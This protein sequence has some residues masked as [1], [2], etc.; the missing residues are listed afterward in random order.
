MEPILSSSLS[1]GW[2]TVRQIASSAA[3]A[4][5]YVRI[6]LAAGVFM[7]AAPLLV[8]IYESWRKKQITN[9]Y[10]QSFSNTLNPITLYLLGVQE[11]RSSQW[12]SSLEM[13]APLEFR[14]M[15]L[16][17]MSQYQLNLLGSRANVV[18][19]LDPPDLYHL[20]QNIPTPKKAWVASLTSNQLLTLL[21][22]KS[23]IPDAEFGTFD[24]GR[25]EP[26]K[27]WKIPIEKL[28]PYQLDALVGRPEIIR[29]L[30]P[31]Q[32]Q[33]LY[34]K[35]TKKKEFVSS[36][37]G[38]NLVALLNLA[39]FA[40]DADFGTFDLGA[41]A[42]SEASGISF[43]RLSQSQLDALVLRTDVVSA[44]STTAL[45]HLYRAIHRNK[46]F[47]A[48]LPTRQLRN[49]LN[50]ENFQLGEESTAAFESA[51]D[52]RT[53]L[54]LGPSK[55]RTMPP[56]GACNIKL[57]KLT[58][59]QLKILMSRPEA[60][61]QFNPDQLL[62]LYQ[63][64]IMKHEEF[65]AS[66][67]VQQLLGLLTHRSFQPR[68]GFYDIVAQRRD[69][70]HALNSAQI[71]YLFQQ[72]S[73]ESDFVRRLMSSQLVDLLNEPSFNL[74]KIFE[75]FDMTL[76]QQ[77]A[78]VD[79]FGKFC[80]V[81]SMH[82]CFLLDECNKQSRIHRFMPLSCFVQELQKC[83]SKTKD[84]IATIPTDQ[85]KFFLSNL[86]LN[87]FTLL[88]FSG[89]QLSSINFKKVPFTLIE[90]QDLGDVHNITLGEAS[91]QKW[92]DT[93]CRLFA[94]GLLGGF[95]G[96]STR[97]IK[98]PE[99]ITQLQQL[100]AQ[101]VAF[102]DR[103]TTGMRNK[104][105]VFSTLFSAQLSDKNYSDYKRKFDEPDTGTG[106]SSK[107]SVK[108]ACQILGLED[109]ATWDEIKAKYRKMALD[110]HP[111]R[112]EDKANAD[113]QKVSEA[114]AFLEEIKKPAYTVKKV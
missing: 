21:S 97:E 74:D 60:V 15:N 16:R 18:N 64:E 88:F 51:L 91:P 52:L 70:V 23:F 114:Y 34:Q 1:M 80:T 76:P 49:L 56:A 57:D 48:A 89:D 94:T 113:F 10:I 59:Y 62:Y 41:I 37:T 108:E 71:V 27:A 35:T 42:P 33:D 58:R 17:T 3:Q 46:E 65:V 47:V 4:P 103:R 5:F 73:N 100:S 98:L 96:P 8:G 7:L 102:L 6:V 78:Q 14:G 36:L 19:Q 63:K 45:C 67:S 50:D 101:Q 30:R 84:K 32:H 93:T 111:D 11:L 20:Y 22:H 54:K 109:T 25:I 77:L 106:A 43:H 90:C 9:I 83:I 104:N 107:L 72:I 75:I 105:I 92:L 82:L 39:S 61:R 110:L 81:S 26:A 29:S 87:Q 95:V 28:S 79:V 53:D 31:T 112:A 68:Q 24:L 85:I 66:F 40:P 86:P 69:L 38:P 12:S 13:M 2:H 44:L 55:L 99:G